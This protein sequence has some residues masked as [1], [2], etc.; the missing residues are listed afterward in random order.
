[1]EHFARLRY[2]SIGDRFFEAVH[3]VIIEKPARE[4]E[5]TP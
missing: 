4:P 3:S 1:L 2:P 5:P